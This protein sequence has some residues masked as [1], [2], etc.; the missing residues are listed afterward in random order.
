MQP[1]IKEMKFATHFQE[2]LD[3][4][5]LSIRDRV[6][7]IA[8]DVLYFLEQ[9]KGNRSL[10]NKPRVQ[11]LY[12]HHI[13][14]DEE[15]KFR[16]LLKKLAK[17]H[18]FISH[19]EAVERILTNK[20]DKPYISFSSDDGL[21]NNLKAAEILNEFGASCCFFINTDLIDSTDFET[22]AKH[23]EEKIDFPATEMLSWDEVKLLQEMGHEIGSH[24][25]NHNKI[26]DM[27]FEQIL[28]DLKATKDV[29]ESQGL[30]CKHFAYP[31]GR[32]FHFNA[33]GK[34]AV[35]EAG[36]YSCSSAE[37]GCHF[38]QKTNF[39]NEEVLFRRDQVIAHWKWQYIFYFLMNNAKSSVGNSNLYPY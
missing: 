36:L 6:R 10:L 2:V 31:Y 18:T 4:K 29:I 27:S 35:Y 13:F 25:L 33:D 19:S 15:V 8:L 12:F 21:K 39:S 37:R 7:S 38:E 1:R 32:F 24:T 30:E 14:E 34:K 28:E 23:C 3:R 20:I 16:A 26:T 11:L 5:P 9:L 22:I 17:N